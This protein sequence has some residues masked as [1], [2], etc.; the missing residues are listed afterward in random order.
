MV[1]VDFCLEEGCY[2]F[3]ISDSYEDGI[4][5]D[6]GEGSWTIT[7]PNGTVVDTGGEFGASEQIQFCADETLG[8]EQLEGNALKAFPV[9]TSAEVTLV[10][11][12]AQG[13]VRVL[14][15]VGRTVVDTQGTGARATWDTSAWAEGTYVVEWRGAEGNVQV[16]RISVAR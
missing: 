2:Q 14:D 6:Y 3:R 7:D 5:C 12:E 8:L 1:T 11:P 16:T 9:P 13:P 4:C 15:L 10:W